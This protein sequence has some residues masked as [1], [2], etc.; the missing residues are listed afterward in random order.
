MSKQC[1]LRAVTTLIKPES[2]RARVHLIS[3]SR[4]TAPPAVSLSCLYYY[5]CTID[6]DTEKYTPADQSTPKS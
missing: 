4:V 1:N 5:N 6:N 2:G 3:N